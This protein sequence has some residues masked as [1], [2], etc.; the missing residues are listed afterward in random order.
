MKTT[1]LREKT[2]AELKETLIGLFRDQFKLRVKMANHDETVK[3]HMFKN[4]RRNIARIKT[5]L[6][7]KEAIN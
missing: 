1:E 4:I 5:I 7:E 3:S 6:T 2:V